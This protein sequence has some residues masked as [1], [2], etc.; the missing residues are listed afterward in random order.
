MASR[1]SRGLAAA[2]L[3][4]LPVAVPAQGIS[5]APRDSGARRDSVVQ[6]AMAI[7]GGASL[8]SYQSGVTWAMIE[9]YR[10]ATLDRAYAARHDLKRYSLASIAGAS[11]GNINAVLSAIEWC[12]GK[13]PRLPEES[14]YWSIWVRVGI[15]Q[16][17]ATA[18][19]LGRNED[20]GLFRRAFFR[21]ELYRDIERELASAATMRCDV[22]I[23]ITL[24]R[25]Y[26]DSFAVQPK[27]RVPIQ[28]FA[29]IFRLV[30][31]PGRPGM[32]F[33]QAH[34]PVRGARAL[35]VLIAPVAEAPDS[36][37]N[38]TV[39]AVV[40]ASSA[41]PVAFAPRELRYYYADSLRGDGSCPRRHD[42]VC[43]DH[44]RSQFIDGGVFDNIPMSLTIGMYQRT[45]PVGVQDPL[46]LVFVD[47][48]LLRG[49]LEHVRSTRMSERPAYGLDAVARVAR[50]AVPSARKYEMFSFGRALS[51]PVANRHDS[52]WVR[53]TS[54][55]YPVVGEHLGSFASFLGRPF[56]EY[57]FF[58]GVYDG[59]YFLAGE[60]FCFG[61][62]D[63]DAREACLRSHMREFLAGEHIAVSP[64]SRA[65]MDA[66]FREDFDTL[67]PPSA[68]PAPGAEAERAR[69]LRWLAD[70]NASL[71]E[72]EPRCHGGGV[73]DQFFCRSG[74]DRVL[75]GFD[76]DSA[77]AVLRSLRQRCDSLG[78]AGDQCSAD[79]AIIALLD[80]RERY[81]NRLTD[82][83]M[84]QAWEVERFQRRREGSRDSVTG[85]KH[86]AVKAAHFLYRSTTEHHRRGLEL[87]P[88]TIPDV[89]NWK[90]WGVFALLPY[91]MVGG[92]GNSSTEGGWRPTW[93]MGRRFALIV[94][95]DIAAFDSPGDR[96][97]LFG[98]VGLGVHVRR[99]SFGLSAMHLSVS[100]VVA[101]EQTYHLS[102][103]NRRLGAELV[104]Y[105]L[106]G[107]FR[108]SI[109]TLAPAVRPALRGRRWMGSIGAADVNG[110]LYWLVR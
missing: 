31:E 33:A 61:S 6:I 43:S 78:I 32:R 40:E 7:S 8:G 60:E 65:V 59:M 66:M 104:G 22:P 13:P 42:G 20:R 100:S 46:T 38:D 10:R 108:L 92:I 30:R 64:A 95:V 105:F 1:L 34:G 63:A 19:D 23:G 103:F 96:H 70:A 55:V 36:I 27:I 58:A 99:Q 28:R 79:D 12:S 76:R 85:S 86:E 4:L 102:G 47:P 52:V 77:R 14:L 106:A 107:K 26:P 3:A 67:P 90:A 89:E 74:F 80:H 44:R 88:S 57:D 83:L 98:S 37:P 50:G 97:E 11:A 110:M 72:F 91:Y 18:S 82:R 101:S 21:D 75:S 24:T 84:R 25:M 51:L 54:R 56:R 35:G 48:G 45:R 73:V 81:L 62:A 39:L 69:L 29:S 109:R 15:D 93:Y 5:L 71:F 94:P 68:S 49:R 9:F 2:A 41:F 87:D 17:L 53:P 16:L